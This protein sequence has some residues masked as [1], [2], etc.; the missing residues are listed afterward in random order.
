MT[1]N[2]LATKYERLGFWREAANARRGK[3]TAHMRWIRKTW[4]F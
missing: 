4:G 1:N 2:D 3:E